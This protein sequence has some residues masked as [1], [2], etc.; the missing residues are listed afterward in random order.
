MEPSEVAVEL[1]GLTK[2]YGALV[3]VDNLNLVVSSGKKF[4]LLGPNGSGKT[5]SLKMLMGVLSIDGGQ[6]IV[7]GTDVA[8]HPSRMRRNVG[9]VPELHYIYRWMTVREVIEFVSYFYPTWDDRLCAHLLD[10]FDLPPDR[11]VLQLSKGML[12]KLALIVATAH[13]PRVLVLDE[14]TSGLDSIAREEFLEGVLEAVTQ[15]NTAVLFSSHAIAD[16][17]RLADDVGIMYRG[18]LLVRR[19]VRELLSTT[20]RVHAILQEGTAPR[21][22]P[23]GTVWQSVTGRQWSLVID[24][25]LP[26]VLQQFRDR[27]SIDNLD[28]LDVDL[29]EV[30]KAHVKGAALADEDVIVEGRS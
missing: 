8:K 15:E 5:T 29:E 4:G 13:H 20:K 26:A 19:S 9:Y 2:R 22:L 14:P 17:Q 6:A 18:K 25:C 10:L 3:A 23:D 27:N 12:V 11:K 7:L 28:V 30:F 24:D 21:W 16:V 1:R